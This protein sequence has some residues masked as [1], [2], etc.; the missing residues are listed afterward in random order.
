MVV[1][2]TAKCYVEVNNIIFYV[3]AFLELDEL[4]PKID[5]GPS[6]NGEVHVN[7][8][9]LYKQID[10]VDDNQESIDL[11]EVKSKS[12]DKGRVVVKSLT[13]SWEMVSCEAQD[14]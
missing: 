2:Q 1:R 12:E 5:A 6:T 3:Q 14:Q 4:E 11:T 10:S 13:S 7:D 9:M 8:I